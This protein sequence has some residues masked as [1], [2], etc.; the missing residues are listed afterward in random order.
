MPETVNNSHNLNSYYSQ[1]HK[2]GLNRKKVVVGPPQIYTKPLFN[3]KE[4]NKRI[5]NINQDIYNST[6]KE[7]KKNVKDFIK[8][9]GTGVLMILAFLGIKKFFK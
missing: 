5:R 4:A 6:Q 2:T 1:N 3:D 7:K 9:F 8:V